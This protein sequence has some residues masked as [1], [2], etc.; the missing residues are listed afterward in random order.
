[1]SSPSFS[2]DY[3]RSLIRRDFDGAAFTTVTL[4]FHLQCF[5]TLDKA[6]EAASL[7]GPARPVTPLNESLG[8]TRL[9][10]CSRAADGRDLRAKLAEQRRVATAVR[11]RSVALRERPQ[12]QIDRLILGR[13]QITSML[14]L[15]SRAARQRF[16]LHSRCFDV[17]RRSCLVAHQSRRFMASGDPC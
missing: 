17:W 14:R 4:R 8:R 1:M 3:P 7:G 2:S 11:E 5:T 9:G 10:V 6:R 13:V 12:A 16:T 15:T